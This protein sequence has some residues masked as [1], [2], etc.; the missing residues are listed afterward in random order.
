MY[1][2]LD[3]I[4]DFGQGG[5]ARSAWRVSSIMKM[6]RR[7]D[8]AYTYATEAGKIRSGLGHEPSTRLEEADFNILLNRMDC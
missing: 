1:G 3:L 6:M 8:E 7:W 2:S 5:K 4:D